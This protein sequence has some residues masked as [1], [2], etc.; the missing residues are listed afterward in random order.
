[1]GA[2][3]SS[4]GGGRR[5]RGSRRHGGA[6]AGRM[7]DINVTPFV[8]VM[9]VLL[10]VFMVAAPLLT[11]GVKIDLPKTSAGPVKEEV[12][13]LSVTIDIDGK[14]FLQDTEIAD[15]V[16]V[17]RLVAI[18]KNGYDQAI[19]LRADKAVGYGRVAEVMSLINSGGFTKL[20]LVNDPAPKSAKPAGT[21]P[22]TDG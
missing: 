11:V 7:S 16:L 19:Y 10:I 22:A 21:R 3:T 5:R 15:D 18:S 13:P 4:G 20:V 12:E 8:D 9:L 6:S 17:P 14:V 1:M 2:A